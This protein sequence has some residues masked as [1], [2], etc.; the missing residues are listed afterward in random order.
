[1]GVG[2]DRHARAGLRPCTW[3]GV[4]RLTQAVRALLLAQ[5][6]AATDHHHAVRRA[7]VVTAACCQA[8]EGKTP[9]CDRVQR[10][11]TSPYSTCRYYSCGGGSVPLGSF[12]P[13]V[14]FQ[15]WI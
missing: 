11:Q 9:R 6:V 14:V 10:G 15:T 5:L 13:G 8:G 2:G 4:G 7:P 12:T 1:M 3:A